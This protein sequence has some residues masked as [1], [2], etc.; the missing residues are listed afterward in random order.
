MAV[1]D[2]QREINYYANVFVINTGNTY[3][4]LVVPQDS[5]LKTPEQARQN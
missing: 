3:T 5:P 1:I 2:V 4:T